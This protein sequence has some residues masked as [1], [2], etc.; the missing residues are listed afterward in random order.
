M[1]GLLAT[2]AA[3][4]PPPTYPLPP[5][6]HPALFPTIQPAQSQVANV[7]EKNSSIQWGLDF[8][9][10]GRDRGSNWQRGEEKLSE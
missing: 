5:P 2:Y 10:F 4:S 3:L 6:P 9:T 8:G 1:S 7:L